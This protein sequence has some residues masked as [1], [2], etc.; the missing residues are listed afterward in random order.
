MGKIYE[1]NEP[2]YDW[3]WTN[4]E[5]MFND[6]AVQ[7][8]ANAAA[9][10]EPVWIELKDQTGASADISFILFTDPTL[11]SDCPNYN[12]DWIVNFL[13]YAVFA[14]EWDWSGPSGGFNNGDLDCDGDVDFKDLGRFCSWWLGYCP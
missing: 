1:S 10:G 7:G 9:G 11:C 3:G 13:D 6:D 8:R 14:N 12:L 4:H 5:H 2:N